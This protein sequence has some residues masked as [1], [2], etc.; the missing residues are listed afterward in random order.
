[1]KMEI[2]GEP[3][4]I[5][6]DLISSCDA[7]LLSHFKFRAVHE[8]SELAMLYNRSKIGLNVQIDHAREAGLSFRV[9]D[10]IACKALLMTPLSSKVLL[11]L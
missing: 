3:K 4:G 10:I 1:M 11:N 9:F 7:K 6:I 2:Y 5:W 8:N